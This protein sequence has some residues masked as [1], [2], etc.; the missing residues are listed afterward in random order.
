MKN[1][2]KIDQLEKHIVEELDYKSWLHNEI[3]EK[4]ADSSRKE[5]RNGNKIYE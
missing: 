3:A 5:M 4:Q 1:D 2:F